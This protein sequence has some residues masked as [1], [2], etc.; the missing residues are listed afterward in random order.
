V[1]A[2]LFSILSQA[3]EPVPSALSAGGIGAVAI[4]SYWFISLSNKEKEQLREDN[5][6]LQD[7]LRATNEKTLGMAERAIPALVEATRTLGEVKAA[8]DSPQRS[9]PG[10]AE[11]ERI[12]RQMERVA[13]DL[14]TRDR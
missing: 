13:E 3:T 14:R 8:M 12:M 10:G 2:E 1:L 7:E 9:A 5:R 11:L 4:F 6:R